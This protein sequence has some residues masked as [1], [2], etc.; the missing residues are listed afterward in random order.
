L[1]TDFR[2]FSQMSSLPSPD[3]GT[4]STEQAPSGGRVFLFGLATAVAISAG[5]AFLDWGVLTLS[6][7]GC[8]VP[9]SVMVG[10]VGRVLSIHAISVLPVMILATL[11][12]SGVAVFLRRGSPEGIQ[13]GICV[14]IAG[15]LV[16]Y[17]S[18]VQTEAVQVGPLRINT[19]HILVVT[20]VATLFVW[21]AVRWLVGTRWGV[22]YRRSLQWVA[23]VGVAAFVAGPFLMSGT[24]LAGPGAYSAVPPV[25]GDR[26]PRSTGAPN[27]LFIVLDTVR[28][29]RLSHYGYSLDTT[30]FLA[31]ISGKGV[32]FDRAI[33]PGMHTA[34]SHASMFTGVSVR[35]H[36]VGSERDV[37]HLDGRFETSAER[38]LA[39]DYQTKS[40]SCNPYVDHSQN[41][42]QG[43]ESTTAV[44]GTWQWSS[45]FLHHWLFQLGTVWSADWIEYDYGAAMLNCLAADWIENGYRSEAPFLLFVNYMEGHRDHHPP[46]S[47]RRQ[48]LD[49]ASVKRSYE[50]MRDSDVLVAADSQYWI[51][52]EDSYAQDD[53]RISMALYDASLRYQDDR[54]REL[55]GL[56]DA[57]GMLDNTIVMV[58]SDHGEGLGEHSIF[59]HHSCVYD[60]LIHV[61]LT[62]Y[63]PRY[64]TDGRRVDTAVS[65]TSLHDLVCAAV[66]AE[67]CPD[68]E[69]L[70]QILIDRSTESPVVSECPLVAPS[71]V[72]RAPEFGIAPDTGIL[73]AFRSIS[74]DGYKYIL[75]SDGSEELYD[76]VADPEEQHDLAAERPLILEPFS[77]AMKQWLE[78]T[79][80]RYEAEAGKSSEVDQRQQ[81]ML[82]ALGYTEE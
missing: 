47:Y 26:A 4:A 77:K 49:E 5:A 42:L 21:G 3:D 25:L 35:E 60:I 6:A 32:T 79:E 46:L 29:D 78:E 20:L 37:H 45:S 30:P 41:L 53:W 16:G 24:A 7:V 13:A 48:F 54:L 71:A 66:T 43:F 68:A 52:P 64:P 57:N 74:R 56:L 23:L 82:K 58:V 40:F 62:I 28:A 27:I 55:F 76:I 2:S 15:V 51:V 34:P 36:G 65:T 39:S 22:W 17:G 50:L 75:A 73:R 38:A 63:V 11:I 9:G 61:P 67:E 31:E 44:W 80:L 10:T 8:D 18:I 70:A 12:L 1:R 69:T 72:R 19:T 14:L 81:D 59:Q 33:A